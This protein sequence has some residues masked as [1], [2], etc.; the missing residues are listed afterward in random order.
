MAKRDTHYRIERDSMGEKQ[1]PADRYWGA[2]TQRSLD[3]FHIGWEKMPAILIRAFGLQK[4]AAARANAALGQLS[5]DKASAIVEAAEEIAKGELSD[6][7]PLSVWQTGSGT[8]TNMN[9]N[10]VIANRAIEKLG[11]ILGSKTPIHPNDDVNKGQSTND[12]FPTAMHIAV[13]LMLRDHLMP[14]LNAFKTTLHQKAY[15]FDH[16][17]K[18]GRTHLQDATP[19]TVGQVFWGYE[20]QIENCIA[21]IEAASPGI[22]ALAQGGTAV[23]TGVG[24]VEGFAERFAKEI[25]DMTDLPFVT[26]PNKFTALAAHDAIVLLSGAL[27]LLATAVFKIAN[28]IRHLASGPRCGLGELKIPENEPGSSIMPGKVNPTQAEALTM[29]A[30]QVMGNHTTISFAGALGNFELNVFKP[31]L[32][33]NIL[34]S[35]QLLADGIRSFDDHCLKGVE[36]NVP[37]I[38]SDVQNS[39]MLATALASHIGYDAAAKIAGYAAEKG[40]SLHEA[41]LALKLVT[42]EEFDAWVRPEAMLAPEPLR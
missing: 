7:F 28:D 17:I 24:T 26:A 33:Y 3:Y 30:A 8:Q 10:E 11:G 6:N 22:Y 16:L 32:A 18:I 12:S 38:R 9:L 20:T 25:S 1:V 5:I 19:I 42:A 40:C 37:K 23:G 13:A 29:I 39:L 15:D 34:Q 2:Q 14:A 27:N 41:A 35:I 31:V 21:A 36:V 4:Q